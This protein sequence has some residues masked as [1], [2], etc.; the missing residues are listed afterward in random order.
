MSPESCCPLAK[1][2]NTKI[3][4][5]L[6]AGEAAKKA[7][8]GCPVADKSCCLK[9]EEV[10]ETCCL[11]KEE[12]CPVKEGTCPGAAKTDAPEGDSAKEAGA[13]GQDEE[14]SPEEEVVEGNWK[15]RKV[16]VSEIKVETGE[17]D[18]DIFWTQRSKLYRWATDTDGTGVWKE[19]GL[20][21]SK[22]LKHRTSGK[23]RF[24]LRQEKT[25]KVVANHYVLESDGLCK[26]TPNVGSDKIWVWTAHNTLEDENKVEQLALK[27]ATLD[28]AKTFKEKFEEAAAVNKELFK[29]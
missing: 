9:K 20:G 19:R 21:D 13:A 15:A 27:F 24:L 29:K 2:A 14:A 7:H 5:E 22:L 10:S 17:E 11:K 26:L 1:D 16:E 3:A 25:F 4:C 6:A 28:Q 18:E 23:I 8:E 12:S